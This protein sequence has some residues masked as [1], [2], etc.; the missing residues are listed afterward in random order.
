MDID[1]RIEELWEDK[2]TEF[3]EQE[4]RFP[5]APSDFQWIATEAMRQLYLEAIEE[6]RPKW[7]SVKDAPLF[8]IENGRWECTKNGC[9]EF[10]GGL[11]TNHGWWQAHC[12]V[13]D[14]I[15]LRIVF[16]GDT[17]PSPWELGDI[18]YYFP[19]PEPPKE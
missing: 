16:D 3:W 19:L 14:E 8:I 6:S 10:M 13:E 9:K 17:E 7:G 4:S 1:K 2:Y 12:I 5:K 11:Y 15:G 18:Q